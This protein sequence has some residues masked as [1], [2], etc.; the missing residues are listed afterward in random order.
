MRARLEK[1]SLSELSR[2]DEAPEDPGSFV[3]AVG[4][5]KIANWSHTASSTNMGAK[6]VLALSPAGGMSVG[7]CGVFMVACT[8]FVT[9]AVIEG[10]KA[11]IS[12]FEL[13]FVAVSGGRA[14][15]VEVEGMDRSR[16][17]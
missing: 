8:A 13:V 15:A 5:V 12:M 14:V 17:G 10:V 1:T 16:L 11:S 7:R 9:A 6:V 3:S 4:D 2:V